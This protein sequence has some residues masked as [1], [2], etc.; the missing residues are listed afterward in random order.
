MDLAEF[1]RIIGQESRVSILLALMGGKALPAGELAFRAGISN[2][3]ASSHLQ[4]LEKCGMIRMRKCGRFHYFEIAGPEISSILEGLAVDLPK[5]LKSV[6]KSSVAPHLRKARLCYDHLAGELG[7]AIS[8]K[9]VHVGALTLGE[10]GFVLPEKGHPIYDR[11]GIDLNSLMSKK[12]QISPRCIDWSERLPHVAG[13][14]GCAIADRLLEQNFITR[15]RDDRSV[16]ITNRGAIFFQ[17]HFNLKLIDLGTLHGAADG[18]CIIFQA[19]LTPVS[20]K[21]TEVDESRHAS[22]IA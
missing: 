9:L 12:R 6:S 15:S 3:T 16:K 10:D 5:S 8:Q 14:L 2:Q 17:D 21:K 13:A 22:D 4:E 20:M 1:G 11:I 18:K 7:I 19:P